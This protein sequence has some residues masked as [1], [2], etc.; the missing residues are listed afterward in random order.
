MIEGFRNADRELRKVEG[1]EN[2][3]ILEKLLMAGAND[4][5]GYSTISDILSLRKK[6]DFYNTSEGG[7]RE[8]LNG[9]RNLFQ[10]TDTESRE[11]RRT[12]YEALQIIDLLKQAATKEDH[13]PVHRPRSKAKDSKGIG[14][15]S[16][17]D[18]ITQPKLV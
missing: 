1:R 11:P 4:A 6:E 18:Q 5:S 16:L 8:I 9:F 7:F 2:K 3:S 10:H 13:I 14:Q 15:Q 12:I 17:Y